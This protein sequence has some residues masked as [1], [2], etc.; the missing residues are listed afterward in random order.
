VDVAT[1][2]VLPEHVVVALTTALLTPVAHEPFEHDPVATATGTVTVTD[3]VAAP[4][5]LQA[6]VMV[7]IGMDVGQATMVSA[8]QPQ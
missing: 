1:A 6:L 3:G 2:Q 8:A 7:V 5:A 4:Q